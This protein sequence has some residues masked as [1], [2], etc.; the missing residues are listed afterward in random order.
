M[1]SLLRKQRMLVQRRKIEEI[2]SII[3]REVE[4][5]RERERREKRERGRE[6]ESEVEREGEERG[7]VR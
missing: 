3:R 7:R 4:G 2:Q 5:V 1:I 6:S